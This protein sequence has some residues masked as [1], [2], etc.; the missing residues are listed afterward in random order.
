MDIYCHYNTTYLFPSNTDFVYH[1]V[2]NVPQ[3][4]GDSFF[5]GTA[6]EDKLVKNCLNELESVLRK[7]RPH[8]FNDSQQSSSQ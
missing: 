5:T 2:S 8:I 6:N 3:T 1:V 4:S 7:F